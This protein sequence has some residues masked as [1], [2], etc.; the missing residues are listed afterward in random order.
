MS[1]NKKKIILFTVFIICIV[2][3]YALAA[4]ALPGVE[5]KATKIES[6]LKGIACVVAGIGLLVCGLKF[7][8]GDQDAW[9]KVWIWSSGAVLIAV[10]SQVSK[11][12]T[13]S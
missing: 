7:I 12:L 9:G 13:S 11:F 10:A 4:D 2:A 1:I 5:A 6:A 3:P 8:K